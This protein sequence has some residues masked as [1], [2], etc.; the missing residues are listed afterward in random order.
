[1]ILLQLQIW[2][3]DSVMDAAMHRARVWLNDLLFS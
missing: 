2:G 3:A 1:M